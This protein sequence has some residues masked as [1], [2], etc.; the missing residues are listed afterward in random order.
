[1]DADT[2]GHVPSSRPVVVAAALEGEEARAERVE[3]RTEAPPPTA[4][5]PVASQVAADAITARLQTILDA[6]AS[7]PKAEPAPAPEPAPEP[8]P[9]AHPVAETVPELDLPTPPETA[10]FNPEPAVFA[11]LPEVEPMTS[12]FETPWPESTFAERA[13]IEPALFQSEP[14][15]FEDF[16]SRRVAHHDYQTYSELEATPTEHIRGLNP[17]MLWISFLA[18]GLV[19]FAGGIFFGF[20][21]KNSG[22][23]GVIGWGL[24]L[25]GIALVATAVYFLLERLGGREEP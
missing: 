17:L 5:P 8:E 16:G 9:A 10:A 1:V 4:E 7:A 20:S 11:P 6:Q 19:V 3:P 13:E 15:T 24:G 14:M 25:L 21:A 12:T 2:T 18:L 22:L 23:G